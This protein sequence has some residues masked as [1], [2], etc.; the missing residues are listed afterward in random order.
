[1]RF[2]YGVW[3]WYL[4]CMVPQTGIVLRYTELVPHRCASNSITQSWILVR[5]VMDFE[6]KTPGET[7]PV[8]A[9][10]GRRVTTGLSML[11]L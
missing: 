11:Q 5:Q 7:H 8:L 4:R 1:M 10:Q 2:I 3:C 6:L 9:T